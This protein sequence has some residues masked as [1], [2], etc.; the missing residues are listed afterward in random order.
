MVKPQL[1]AASIFAIT[2][3]AAYSDNSNQS[4]AVITAVHPMYV[5]HTTQ[6]YENVCRSVEVPV[7]SGGANPSS[8][9]VL[10]GAIIGGAIGNQFGNGNGKDVM[11]ML[12]AIIGAQSAKPS[13]SIVGYKI[14]HR[15]E[16]IPVVTSNQVISHYNIE[17]I[18][19]GTTYRFTT[20]QR[21]TLGERVPIGHIFN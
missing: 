13:H 19:G 8:A 6:H 7:Y 14:E 9:D 4:Y 5:N 16:T 17:Y 20:N 15:C 10:T 21:Y 18:V 11:T 2:A 12:G 3:T 1:A